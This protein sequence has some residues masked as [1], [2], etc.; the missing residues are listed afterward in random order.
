MVV[1]APAVPRT[2]STWRVIYFD[3]PNR[4]EQIRILFALSNTPFQDVR[5]SPFPQGLDPYKKAAM[6]DESP[7]LGTDLCPAVT[8]P[9]GTHCVETT[10]IMRFVG[11]RVGLAPKADSA[12][13]KKAME[14]CVL[15]NSLMNSVFYGLL[16]PMIV[17]R[18]FATEFGGLLWRLRGAVGGKPSPEPAKRLQE[19]LPQIEEAIAG[20][21]VL[22]ATMCYA[23]VS[24]FAILRE[25]LEFSVFDRAALLAPYP[26]LTALLDDV[27]VKA[28]GWIEERVEKHQ[29]GI[30]ST[31][32]FFAQTNTPVP[33]SRKRK[34]A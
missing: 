26:K 9:D 24:L 13:D 14:L 5:V 30:R 28:A 1:I 27:E 34:T 33:W 31:I 18:I 3:A 22:G 29:L 23:D 4:G 21:Y 20:P 19:A 32:D 2:P 7:L 12:E 17:E 16:K 8:A 6:G 25:I 11:Q 15:A 10:D